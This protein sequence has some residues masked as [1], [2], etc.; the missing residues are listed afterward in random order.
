MNDTDLYFP[1]KL[2]VTGQEIDISHLT[3]TQKEF[4]RELLNEV[5]A[6]YEKSRKERIII[7]FTGP[8]GSGKSVLTEILKVLAAH[9]SRATIVTLGIDAYS[10]TIEYLSREKDI[11]G[12]LL[13]DHKGRFDTYDVSKLTSDLS[14]FLGGEECSLPEYS[15]VLHDPVEGVI[16][17]GAGPAIMLLEGIW[18]LRDEDGWKEVKQYLEFSYFVRIDKERAKELVLKRH[19]RGGRTEEDA[20]RHYERSDEVNFDSIMATEKRAD[21][22]IPSFTEL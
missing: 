8:S 16:N 3:E 19:V 22:S 14:S 18:L 21:K 15:R 10:Y 2:M 5:F 13:L 17:V 1:E 7:G 6:L 4:Y 9:S 11:D 12:A 20:L